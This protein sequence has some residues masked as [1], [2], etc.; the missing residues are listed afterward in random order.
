MIK[1]DGIVQICGGLLE[2]L[3]QN[4]GA[5]GGGGKGVFVKILRRKQ[6]QKEKIKYSSKIIPNHTNS[7]VISWL[8]ELTR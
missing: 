5:E 3:L 2:S 6:D 1:N 8:R 7:G 4:R